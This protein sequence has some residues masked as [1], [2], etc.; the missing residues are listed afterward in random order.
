MSNEPAQGRPGRAGPPAEAQRA[1]RIPHAAPPRPALA[2]GIPA[3][4]VV[5]VPPPGPVRAALSLWLASFAA[6]LV[7]AL[8]AFLNRRAQIDRLREA[9]AGLG[10]G[11]DASTLDTVASVA[12][13]SALGALLVLMAVEALL[14]AVLLRTGGWPRWVLLVV[15]PVH[16]AVMVVGASILGPPGAETYLVV[17]LAAQA[18]LGAAALA[19]SLLPRA[20]A[21]FRAGRNSAGVPG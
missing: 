4:I 10:S 13:W 19:A 2:P 21:W 12:W 5:S 9:A 11:R 15:L 20:N 18:V 7:A 3:P 16:V 6:G 17:L 8:V 1:G 14:L